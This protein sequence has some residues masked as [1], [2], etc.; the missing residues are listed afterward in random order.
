MP[1]VICFHN[2]DEENGYLSNWYPSG[3]SYSEKTYSSMEQYMM[4]QKALC[5]SDEDIAR[6]ILKTD[7]VA[8]IKKL[9]RLVSNYNEHIWDGVRQIVIYEGLTAKFSQ[10][11]DLKDQL[12]ATG[13]AILAECAVKDKVWGIG[14]SMTDPDRN[15]PENWK[16]RNL[17]GYSLMLVRKKLQEYNHK[18]RKDSKP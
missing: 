17:L 18:Q 1:K 3:F 13:D 8:E 12:M 2:P 16:G 4:H 11:A 14:L 9:G 6:Q 10:N 7:D 5:F 15:I